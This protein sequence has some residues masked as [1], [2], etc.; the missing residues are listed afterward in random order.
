MKTID[1]KGDNYFG[2][3]TRSR[4]ACR[5]I[6]IKDG[7]ILLSYETATDQWM[8]PG[9]GLEEGETRE[10]CVVR[11]IAEETGYVV[12]P[13]SECL[14]EIDEYY[15]DCKWPSFYYFCEITGST[16]TKLTPQEQ[17]VGMVPKWLPVEEIVKI[18]SRHQ[19]YADTDE[20]RRGMYF[21]EY[22]ALTNILDEYRNKEE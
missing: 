8:L 11:E 22:T 10:E 5:A 21:R 1:I 7:K 6:I 17:E 14:L 3:W 19:D 2:N 16:E 13:A 9:G 18:F 12:R 4:S 20:M 15:E